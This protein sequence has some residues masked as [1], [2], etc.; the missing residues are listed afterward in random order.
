MMLMGQELGA[1]WGLGFKRS[2]FLRAR[3]T[4]SGDGMPGAEQLAAY[5]LRMNAARL[6]PANRALLASSHGYLR[7]RDGGVD[8]RIFAQVKW[9]PDAN[10]VFVFHNLWSQDVSQVYAVPADLASRIALDAQR[11]YRLFDVLSNAARGACKT[12]SDLR[13]EGVYV[14]MSAAT[15][16]QWLRLETCD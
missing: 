14:A 5:Y 1:G 12:G 11:R 7:T 6:D 8:D 4:G 15:R 16:A 13:S 9:S 2:D 10:V 3:F